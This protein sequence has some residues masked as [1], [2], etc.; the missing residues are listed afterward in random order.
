MKNFKKVLALVLAVATVF[1]FAAMANAAEVKYD[2]LT[3]TASITHVEAVQVLTGVGVIQGFEDK[4]FKPAESV[5]RV[6]M[7]KM[8]GFI[9]NDGDDINDLYKAACPFADSK[10]N[11]GAGYIA[12]CATQ[13][14]VNGRDAN[15]FD[16]NA[17]V[18]GVEAAKMLLCAMGYDATIEGFTGADW[19]VNVL[20]VAKKAGLL[21]DL[22]Q[23][24]MGAALNREDA[25]QMIFNALKAEEVEYDTKGTTIE[26]NGATIATGASKAATVETVHQQFNGTKGVKAPLLWG[27]DHFI[28][29]SDTAKQLQTKAVADD[30]FGIGATVWQYGKDADG[31]YIE[32]A[33]TLTLAKTFTSVVTAEDIYAL[34]GKIDA[35][36]VVTIKLDGTDA[37]VVEGATLA[38]WKDVANGGAINKFTA[39][40]RAK[41]KI[42][43]D[44]I[45]VYI[46]DNAADGKNIQ[47][48]GKNYYIGTVT[49]HKAAKTVSD[50]EYVII[51]DKKAEL[52]LNNT[53]GKYETTAFT[54]ADVDDETMVIFTFSKKAGV[55]EIQSLK[56]IDAVKSGAVT[57]TS[58]DK[59]NNKVITADGK[60]YTFKKGYAPT[61][62]IDGEYDLYLD[63]NG[64]VIFAEETKSGSSDYF[65]VM[66]K[67]V[68]TSSGLD[69]ADTVYQVR[70][71]GADGK[72]TDLNVA[73]VNG[74]KNNAGAAFT[75]EWNKV[76]PATVPAEDQAI[77][78]CEVGTI[79]TY[80]LSNKG[81]AKLTTAST[82]WAAAAKNIN[83]TSYDNLTNIATDLTAT[84]ASGRTTFVLIS[85]DKNDNYVFTPVSGISA[86]K[87]AFGNYNYY[88]DITVSDEPSKG[89]AH[90][91]ALSFIFVDNRNETT[92]KTVFSTL[93]ASKEKTEK[94]GN[95]TWTYREV[96]VIEGTEAK[97]LKVLAA[98]Y[99]AKLD[100]N[101]FV[102]ASGYTVN[103]SGFV[104]KVTKAASGYQVDFVATE[105]VDANSNG[106]QDDDEPTT[107]IAGKE[108]EYED[109]SLTING[110]TY[111]NDNIKVYL[112]DADEEAF[113]VKSVSSLKAAD[114]AVGTT[115]TYV[116]N[117]NNASNTQNVTAI[118][119]VG[120]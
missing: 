46:D 12:Y 100:G 68:V 118:Y 99:D 73:E 22:S 89:A 49:T 59:D 95:D 57:K 33:K 61:I 55:N 111:L 66:K 17:T 6:Q 32:I 31:Q 44:E 93:G 26:I 15:T 72:T 92:T 87:S 79:V 102:V 75:T 63:P 120:A 83:I 28:D 106:K 53:T 74:V 18:T 45:E 91:A 3:D 114:I 82:D 71:L 1:T 110:K 51:N 27:E 36:D 67:G 47:I 65:M 20:N 34:R 105:Y 54:D 60:T 58:T 7:A 52:G 48:I 14:I 43:A 103:D 101:T 86:M 10:S 81:E 2:D 84:K 80:T 117:T 11:W 50:K 21:T 13:G 85:L 112:W 88:K 97:T 5:T 8:V 41:N 69:A 113:T 107:F 119:A 108:I 116:M 104:S 37:A 38:T 94:D 16:P 40:Q 30:N 25:A 42:F 70:L 98:E 62:E 78:A 115:V 29:S 56:K 77:A 90:T 23:G 109:G 4:T 19:S 35:N 96:N 64:K 24:K 76:A 39:A 9:M